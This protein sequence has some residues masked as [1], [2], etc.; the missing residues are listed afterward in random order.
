MEDFEAARLAGMLHLQNRAGIGTLAERSLHAVLKYWFQPDERFHE[1]KVNGLVA[2]IFDGERVMEIQTRSLYPLRR[3][4]ERL[5]PEWPVTVVYPV[6]RRKRLIWV[7]PEGGEITRPRLSPKA[8]HPWDALTELFWLA[9]YLSHPHFTLILVMLD[10]EEYRLR[11]GWGN[12]GKRG[13]H[14]VER[15]PVAAGEMVELHGPA[16]Y[17]QLLPPELPEPF[18]TADFARQTRMSRKMTGR[19]INVL[20]QIGAIQRIGKQGNAYLYRVAED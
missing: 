14:R 20:Y 13:S 7:D 1:V 5:L 8:G 10:M 18:T 17:R 19:A 3:K 11:D 4:L 2:D 6:A 12:G 9:P 16:A 15:V